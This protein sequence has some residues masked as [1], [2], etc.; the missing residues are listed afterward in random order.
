MSARDKGVVFGSLATR[1]HDSVEVW[2]QHINI[3]L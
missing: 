1:G 2:A 3:N